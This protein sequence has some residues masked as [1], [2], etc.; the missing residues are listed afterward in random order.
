MRDKGF[1][2]TNIWVYAH[3]QDTHNKCEMAEEFVKESL[4]HWKRHSL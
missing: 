2:D 4:A 1:I 3:L